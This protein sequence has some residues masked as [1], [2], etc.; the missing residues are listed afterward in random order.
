MRHYVYDSYQEAQVLSASPLELVRLLYR[1]AIE[2]IRTAR[3]CLEARD[4]AG[5]SQ[6]IT[7]ALQIV[8][9]LSLSLDRQKAAELSRTLGELYNYIQ[10][11]LIDANC[12]QV[13]P[14]LAEAQELMVTLQEAW[15][16]CEPSRKTLPSE[17][18][19]GVYAPVSCAG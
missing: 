10:R 12:R 16:K 18:E 7:K 9:E 15:E 6:A 4:I 8:A 11:L 13:D 19:E 2:A 3:Q 17:E 14:P 1:G 5:R